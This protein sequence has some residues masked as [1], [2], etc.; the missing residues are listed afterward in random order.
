M[1]QYRFVGLGFCS[2]DYLALLPRIPLDSKVQM[3]KHLVQGGGPAATAAV[4][5]ARLGVSTAFLGV[6]GDDEPGKWILRDFAAENVS[7]EGMV[8]R[9]GQSSA[10]AYCWIDAPTGKRSVAWTRGTLG[11]LQPG[12]VDLDLVRH[13]G[14]LHLDGH[15]PAA[16]LAAAREA[17]QCGV[18]VSLDAGTWRDGMKELLPYVDLLIASEEFARAYSREEDLDKAIL[19][20]RETG[21]G[22]VGIT[23][24]KAG[25]MALEGDRVVRCPAFRVEAVDTTGAG[26]V[27]HAAF[28]VR[29]LETRDLYECM[30][31]ASATAALKCLEL[32]GRAGIPNRRR[33]DEFLAQHP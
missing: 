19:R 25:S 26:D 11:E 12:E 30:R 5:A 1:K 8:V 22:V 33:V 4:A 18:P 10:I 23:M 9:P 16:A 31:F 28:A 24:G 17:K 32:G 6:T 15:N 29:Y 27:Y 20:L 2:N 14:I 7:T 13:A 21:A 3:M